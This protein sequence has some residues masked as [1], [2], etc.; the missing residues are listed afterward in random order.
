MNCKSKSCPEKN[1]RDERGVE[2]SRAYC[3]EVIG[4]FIFKAEVR[5]LKE[6]EIRKIGND[7]SSRSFCI[8]LVL[9][10]LHL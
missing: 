9:S 10:F 7:Y 2:S 4:I 6:S 3:V 8:I 1:H 5:V